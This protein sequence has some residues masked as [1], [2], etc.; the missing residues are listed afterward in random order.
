MKSTNEVP[1]LRIQARFHHE[2]P[3]IAHIH[4][5][6][7]EN[8]PDHLADDLDFQNPDSGF[9]HKI[10]NWIDRHIGAHHDE[11]Q[12]LRKLHKTTHLEILF[13]HDQPDPHLIPLHLNAYWNQRKSKHL[14]RMILAGALMIS[15][16][17]LTALP[18][19]N[20]LGL[21]FTYLM[22]HHWRILQGVRKASTG[23]ILI[24]SISTA[25]SP[26]NHSPADFHQ[27][28]TQP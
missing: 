13:P 21:G 7:L 16:I 25:P 8:H 2:T 24:E 17:P 15:A 6:K 26:N 9:L 5:S 4:W 1:P 3:D 14:R 28:E 18:G 11:T 10:R 27:P 12:M 22:W 20:V 23:A 19:P